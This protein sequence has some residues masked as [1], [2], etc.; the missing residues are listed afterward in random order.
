MIRCLALIALC[1]LSINAELG[2]VRFS[3]VENNLKLL[4]NSEKDFDPYTDNGGTIVGLAG[5]DYVILAADTRLADTA[6]YFISSRECTRIH[7]VTEDSIQ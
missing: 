6:K 7:M 5:K 2:G 3:A 1:L 4:Q